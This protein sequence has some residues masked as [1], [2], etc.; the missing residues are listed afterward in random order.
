[1]DSDLKAAGP[2]PDLS[3][4]MNILHTAYEDINLTLSLLLLLLGRQPPCAA[5]L[6]Y[7]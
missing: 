2:P 5:S 1:M 7:I 3:S 4:E 6:L